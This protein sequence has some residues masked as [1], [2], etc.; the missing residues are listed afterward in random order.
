MLID[1]TAWDYTPWLLGLAEHESLIMDENYADDNSSKFDYKLY[2]R[3]FMGDNENMEF[4]P[5]VWD[6]GEPATR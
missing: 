1:F 2:C 3:H 6:D 4:V 5:M